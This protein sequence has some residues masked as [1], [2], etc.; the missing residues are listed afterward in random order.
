METIEIK[1]IEG[2]VLYSYTCENNNISKTLKQASR[3]KVCLKRANLAGAVIEN[4][5]LKNLNLREAN[6]EKAQFID[7]KIYNSCLNKVNLTNTYMYNVYFKYTALYAIY[8]KYS[9]IVNSTFTSCV[10]DNA[11]FYR[12]DICNNNFEKTILGTYI[13]LI[14]YLIM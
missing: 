9:T 13:L 4:V 3:E 6:F 8:V 7:I 2:K 10:L 11:L 14:Q 5:V 12:T 1:N